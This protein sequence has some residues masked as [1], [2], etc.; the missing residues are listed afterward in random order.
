M[1]RVEAEIADRMPILKV[2]GKCYTLREGIRAAQALRP[3]VVL[4]DGDMKGIDSPNALSGFDI[5]GI[6][7]ILLLQ[8]VATRLWWQGI[9]VPILEKPFDVEAFARL[10]EDS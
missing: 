2:I 9:S 5:E 6:K 1:E 8:A 4:L 3:S 7:L 10:L